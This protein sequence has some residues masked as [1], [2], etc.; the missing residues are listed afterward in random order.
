MSPLTSLQSAQT[1][2]LLDISL[3]EKYRTTVSKSY[4]VQTNTQELGI[5]NCCKSKVQ[6]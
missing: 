1:S 2:D 5:L 4:T 3:W 6:L